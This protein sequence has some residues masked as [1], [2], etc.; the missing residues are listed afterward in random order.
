MHIKTFNLYHLHP[1]CISLSIS[2]DEVL[3]VTSQ[4]I[5]DENRT[6]APTPRPEVS[7]CPISL[8]TR[9]NSSNIRSFHEFLLP[10]HMKERI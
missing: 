2:T 10:T 6:N 3:Q 5:I 1:R 8:H 4:T 9:L 7:I